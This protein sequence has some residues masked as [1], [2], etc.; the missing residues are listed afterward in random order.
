MAMDRQIIET[1]H[2][3]APL[4]TPDCTKGKAKKIRLTKKAR[5][6]FVLKDY[7]KAILVGLFLPLG[8]RGFIRKKKK[9][10]LCKFYF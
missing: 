8:G 6:A 5:E 2:V 9:K 10:P 7:L 3:I 4:V 1:A